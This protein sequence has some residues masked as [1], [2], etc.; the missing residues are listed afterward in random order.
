MTDLVDE[1]HLSA[2]DKLKSRPSKEKKNEKNQGYNSRKP[3]WWRNLSWKLS[4]GQKRSM[5]EILTTHK[6]PSVPY[7]SF[8]NWTEL[9][10]EENDIWLEI[11]FGKGENLLALAHRKRNQSIS[12]VG[13]E[14]HKAGVA[15]AC[16]R[17]EEGRTSKQYW[18]D[19]V[20]YTPEFD[21]YMELSEQAPHSPD[22][23]SKNLQSNEANSAEE[24]VPYDNLRIHRGDGVNKLPYIPSSSLAAVLVTF[25]DPFSK[26][27]QE[28]WRVIQLQ[29]LLEMHRI[30]RKSS[31]GFLFLATDHQGFNEWAHQVLN[32]LN[33][34]Q[35]YFRKVEPCPD[36]V[37]W[38]PV[39]SAYERKGWDEGRRTNLNCWEALLVSPDAN[40]S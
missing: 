32:Q 20:L 29:T 28:E 16:Q 14:I 33:E 19:Y 34:E 21:S 26:Q 11:G 10:P 12:F 24:A 9:F 40:E 22:A 37:E 23:E 2:E 35:Q 6:L 27:G 17:I 4:K 31:S 7:G 38:L 13:A 36:R 3:R 39:V 15:T 8:I 1:F 30:L 25:P 18:A 5:D